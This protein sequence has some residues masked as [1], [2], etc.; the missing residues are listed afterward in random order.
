MDPDESELYEPARDERP[1]SPMPGNLRDE[2][3][4]DDT[5]FLIVRFKPGTITSDLTDL[6]AAVRQAG[7][8]H[9]DK[10]LNTF[11]LTGTPVIRAELRDQLRK[12]E[13]ETA[14]RKFAPDHSL[15]SYWRIDGRKAAEELAAIEAAL[16]RLPEIQVAYREK[17]VSG[18]LTPADDP[19]CGLQ[20][21]LDEAKQGVNARWVWKLDYGHGEGM[22]FIDLE[23]DWILDHEDL[24]TPS[25]IFND[26]R[27]GDGTYNGDHGTG[28][29]GVVAGVDNAVGIVGIAPEVASVRLVSQW[30]RENPT[31]TYIA[32]A[33]TKAITTPPLP[34]VLLIEAQLGAL[35]LP[36]E[37]DDTVLNAIRSAAASGVIVVETAGNGSRNLDSEPDAQGQLRLNRKS[38]DYTDSG[39]VLVGA[40]TASFPHERSIW[41]DN[42]GSNFGSRIDCYAWGDS[43]VTCGEGSLGGSGT[44]SYTDKFGGTSGAAAIIAGCALLLQG[45]HFAKNNSLLSPSEMREMLS[46]KQ[47]G[48][49]Q[50][51]K[52]AGCIGVMPDL[53]AVVKRAKL[54]PNI[55]IEILTFRSWRRMRSRRVRAQRSMI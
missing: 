35:K 55:F 40:A 1:N 16:R 24:P 37:T 53:R 34:H 54:S 15:L 3:I 5:G 13:D 12:L 17:T 47:T 50:G 31:A 9:I 43:I 29:V 27:K 20:G 19:H 49:A 39:A 44:T 45:L 36:P 28:V 30:D 32:E 25:L 26:N 46:C 42:G 33:I 51:V 48:T 2:T 38:L 52:V 6:G 18:P 10:L 22:H 7:L 21:Y 8:L 41:P 4:T 14:Q 23:Q 11:N